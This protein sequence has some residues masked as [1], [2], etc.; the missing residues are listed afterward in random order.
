MT[1]DSESAAKIKTMPPTC[2]GESDSDYHSR[3]YNLF[4]LLQSAS[5]KLKIFEHVER[6]QV[7]KSENF[8]SRIGIL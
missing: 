5:Q 8:V 2:I 3:A 4:S 6:E 1:S 7:T